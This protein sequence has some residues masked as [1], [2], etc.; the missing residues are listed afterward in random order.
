MSE[1]IIEFIKKNPD[2]KRSDLYKQFPDWDQGHIR[3]K[4]RRLVETHR[5]V[6][7]LRVEEEFKRIIH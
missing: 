4:V 3:S 6:E 1:L 7:R 2:C 5:V